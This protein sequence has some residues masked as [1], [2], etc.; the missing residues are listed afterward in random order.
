MAQSGTVY[1][2]E[3]YTEWLLQGCQKFAEL[4]H[5]SSRDGPGVGDIDF[6]DIDKGPFKADERYFIL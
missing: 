4:K 1:V 6:S 5:L 3:L 2:T